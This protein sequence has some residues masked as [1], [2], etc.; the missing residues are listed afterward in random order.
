[1]ATNYNKHI[2]TNEIVRKDN[3]FLH[4]LMLILHI[5]LF[6]H[7][8]EQFLISK[9]S[10]ISYALLHLESHVLGFHM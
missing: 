9:Y 8:H 1:M 10:S 2:T 3:Y 7:L 5:L 4:M 6:T